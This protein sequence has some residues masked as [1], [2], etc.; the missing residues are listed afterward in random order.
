MYGVAV[1][2][3]RN[4]QFLDR[5]TF[6]LWRIGTPFV[7]GVPVLLCLAGEKPNRGME[8]RS[9]K[10]NKD[11]RKNHKKKVRVVVLA[12]FLFGC[13]FLQGCNVCLLYTSRCV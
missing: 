8:E 11:E 7:V 1:L 6:L 13:L 5:V 9:S 10:E 12:C 2:F 3:Y 4:Q